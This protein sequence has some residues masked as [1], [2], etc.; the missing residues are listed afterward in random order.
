[1]SSIGWYST[2]KRTEE[3]K[4]ELLPALIVVPENDLTT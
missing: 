3:I 4:T 1:M 2:G